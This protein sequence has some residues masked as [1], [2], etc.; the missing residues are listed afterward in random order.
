MRPLDGR[1]RRVMADAPTH[2]TIQ[3]NRPSGA[4]VPRGADKQHETLAAPNICASRARVTPFPWTDLLIIAGL[5]VLNGVFR[6]ERTGH[7]FGAHRAAA[8][9]S[10]ARQRGA[11]IALQLGA[12]PG[13]F[14]STVQ[15][16]ITL[17]GIIAGAYSGASLGRPMG[18][19][20]IA[21]RS[22]KLGRPGGLRHRDC[23][24][25]LSKPCRWRARAAQ[26][27]SPCA[28]PRPLPSSWRVRWRCWPKWLRRW[29]GCSMCPRRILIRCCRGAAGK[30]AVFVDSRFCSPK[31]RAERV[32]EHE[33]PL[34]LQATVSD[35]WRRPVRE[36]MTP[37]TEVDWIDIAAANKR[38]RGARVG[39]CAAMRLPVAE[40]S[41]D[42]VLGV[43]K[44]RDILSRLIAK[45][46]VDIASADDEAPRWCP[47]N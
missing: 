3:A 6:H 18:G 9:G 7:R 28:L 32:I 21:R 30:A 35:A 40:T 14:L 34:A 33:Q 38:L 37:R 17:I 4:A 8:H 24:D 25:D 23:R 16:G 43:V 29:C 26:A 20:L 19:R 10:A 42:R 1:C 36:L 45:Q 44:V 47:T 41:P 12:E 2:V 22:R 39:K 13:K 46:P 15:I 5:I 27:R 31:P 11:Q